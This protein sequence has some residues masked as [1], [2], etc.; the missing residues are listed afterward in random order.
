MSGFKTNGNMGMD[1]LGKEATV[2]AVCGFFDELSE[3]L[4]QMAC[5][6]VGEWQ[7]NIFELILING[8]LHLLKVPLQMSQNI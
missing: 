7:I 2:L 5:E 8:N 4:L 3:L 6:N 1:V